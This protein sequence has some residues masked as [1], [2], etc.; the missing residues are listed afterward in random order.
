M[1]GPNHWVF[2]YG[3]NLHLEDLSA[4]FARRDQ[5]FELLG[6]EPAVLHEHQLVWNYYSEARRGGAANVAFKPGAWVWGAALCVRPASLH[7][8]DRKEGHPRVY[9]RVIKSVRLVSGRWL[10]AWTYFVQPAYRRPQFTAPTQ[11]YRSLLVAGA[12][13]FRLPDHWRSHL[14]TIRTC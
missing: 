8:F 7:G 13:R 10:G 2:A 14:E 4:W 9:R 3:S 5:Q 12:H 6:A 1:S 11:H